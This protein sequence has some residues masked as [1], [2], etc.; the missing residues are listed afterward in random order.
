MFLSLLVTCVQIMDMFERMLVCLFFF[1]HL[2]SLTMHCAQIFQVST[3]IWKRRIQEARVSLFSF[4]WWS[5]SANFS[6]Q[7]QGTCYWKRANWNSLT[8]CINLNSRTKSET[9]TL[10]KGN[11]FFFFFVSLAYLIVWLFICSLFIN[12]YKNPFYTCHSQ[13]IF[14]RRKI[15]EGIYAPWL[16]LQT[17]INSIEFYSCD[18]W[19]LLRQSWHFLRKKKKKKKNK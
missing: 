15:F 12:C 7:Y 8:Y 1:F 13:K 18:W 11:F 2:A 16:L 19:F 6:T 14:N 10:L 5:K 3:S 17:T 9:L 4:F